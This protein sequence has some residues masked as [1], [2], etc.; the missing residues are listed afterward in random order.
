MDKKGIGVGQVFVFIVAALTFSVILIYGYKAVSSFVSSGEQVQLV[1][2]KTTLESSV[3]KIYTEYGSVRVQDFRVP[4]KF[5]QIC[6]VDMNYQVTADSP[7]MAALCHNDSYACS[8]W[9]DAQSVDSSGKKKGYAG[10]D[11]NVFLKP[12]SAELPKIKVFSISL[13]DE[14]EQPIGFLC[15]DVHG[16][17][18]SMMMEGK[19][20]HTQLSE[21][22]KEEVN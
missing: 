10:V 8:V 7:E 17:S 12:A 20:D 22:P 11:E 6:F 2:F 5:D 3:K 15:L 1:Q 9:E 13:I 14:L 19:G 16:G 18:F 21:K 4:G